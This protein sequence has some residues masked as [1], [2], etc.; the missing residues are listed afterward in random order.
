MSRFFLEVYYSSFSVCFVLIADI[1]CLLLCSVVL[2]RN[3]VRSYERSSSGLCVDQRPC[4]LWRRSGWWRCNGEVFWQWHL[5]TNWSTAP[6]ENFAARSFVILLIWSSSVQNVGQELR[7]G[8]VNAPEE[9]F[10]WLEKWTLS[11]FHSWTR[12]AIWNLCGMATAYAVDSSLP[13]FCR[14]LL[15]ICAK[16][17]HRRS[18]KKMQEIQK[19]NYIKM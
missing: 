8:S 15:T 19:R 4:C 5:L 9:I 16:S 11:R 6:R 10:H 18:V 2:W 1:Q 17:G 13:F 14:I 12:R 3:S 7:F